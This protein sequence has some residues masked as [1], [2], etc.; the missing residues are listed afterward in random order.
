MMMGELELYSAIRSEIVVNH[1][2][3]HVTTIFVVFV[4][5]AGVWLIE[6]RSSILSLLL[7]LL[8][9]AWAAAMVRF[10]FFIH[11]Q[12]AYLR[13]LETSLQKR[14]GTDVPFWELTKAQFQSTRYVVP[15]AD[16]LGMLII[17]VTTIYLL[18]ES[19]KSLFKERQWH[20]HLVYAWTVLL[21]IVLLL[22]SLPLI[23]KIAGV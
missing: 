10:D 9:L 16:T 2:L 21:L 22:A 23:P 13:M 20:G 6:R 11:R 17:L 5:L 19:C 3:M 12:A 1:V 15:T 8:S 7:P 18:F 4:L 14:V